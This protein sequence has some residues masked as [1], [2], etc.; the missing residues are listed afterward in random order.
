MIVWISISVPG[1]LLIYV[2][3]IYM[4]MRCFTD[5]VGSR[6]RLQALAAIDRYNERFQRRVEKLVDQYD[7]WA[8]SN[9]IIAEVLRF[10]FAD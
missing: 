2:Y 8:R 5:S 4:Q 9:L 10:V 6:L 3:I 1:A 7:G